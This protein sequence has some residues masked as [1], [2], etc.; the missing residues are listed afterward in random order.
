MG[1]VRRMATGPANRIYHTTSE[2]DRHCA[3]ATSDR[4]D[5][6]QCCN[7]THRIRCRIERMARIGFDRASKPIRYG[8]NTHRNVRCRIWCSGPTQ[9]NLFGVL[10]AACSAPGAFEAGCRPRLGSTVNRCIPRL[11]AAHGA[12]ANCSPSAR[13]SGGRISG[14]RA[15]ED[16]LNALI[17]QLKK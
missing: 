2:F 17:G 6:N 8:S 12:S 11:R 10:H 7:F 16:S 9:S 14:G 1:R 4:S 5:T 3:S 15:E 13:R